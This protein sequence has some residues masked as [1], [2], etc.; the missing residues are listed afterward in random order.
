MD[1]EPQYFEERKEKARKVYRAKRTI[2]NP[3]LDCEVVLN[4]DGFHHLQFSSRRERNKKEQLLKFRLLPLALETI[5][6]SGTLQEYRHHLEPL[7]RSTARGETTLKKV[8][9]WAFVSILGPH[10]GPV[11]LRTVLRRVGDGNI[12]FWSVMPYMRFRKGEQRLSTAGIED[13]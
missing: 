6:R 13:E 5:R 1:I 11:K 3:Y 12:I 9:Y 2:Y 10:E 7:G 8:E 4:S